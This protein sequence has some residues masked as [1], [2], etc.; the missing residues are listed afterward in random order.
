MLAGPHRSQCAWA[1]PSA[2]TRLASLLAAAQGCRSLA[3]QGSSAFARAAGASEWRAVGRPIMACRVV[4]MLAP[5]GRSCEYAA[6]AS[7]HRLR[8]VDGSVLRRVVAMPAAPASPSPAAERAAHH[9]RRSQQRPGHVR[10][11]AGQDAQPR[12]PRRAR[13]P[14][15]P[16]L[17]PVSAVQP[18]PCLAPDR[19]AAGHDPGPRSA[20][21]FPDACCR[22]SSRCRRCSGATA[23]SPRA[24]ARSTTTAIPG[25]SARAGST[26]R[27]RGKCSSTRAASTRTKRRKLTNF[28]PARGLGSALAY[29]ASPAADEEHTDG[30]VAAET[31]ALLEKHKDRPFFIG[32]GF[33]RPHCPVHRAA[34][35]LRS[36]SAGQDSRAGRIAGVDGARRR[37]GSPTRRTGGS[38]S[39]RSGKA[40]GRTTRRSAFSTRTSAGSSTRSIACGLTDNTIVVFVSDHGYHLGEHGQWM[41]QTLFERSARAPLDR[42]RPGRRREGARDVEGRRVRSTSIPT[43]AALAGVRAAARSA[44]PLAD[45]APEESGRE[46][47]PPGAHA[48]PQRSGGGDVHGLQHSHRE[49][50]IH[51]MGRGQAGRGAVRRGR[52]SAASRTTSLKTRQHQKVVADMQR[53]LQRVSRQRLRP[54]RARASVPQRERRGPAS[55]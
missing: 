19:A 8:T 45:A 35:V 44:R 36:V 34:E 6:H 52:R 43:L 37:R 39:R 33:Y 14:L 13:R 51:G 49:V 5:Q 4:A 29:Y 38:A 24:S 42:R 40:S 17:H 27:R 25:R 28:T 2:A 31:I 3:P 50:A 21:G 12:S 53:L 55:S 22:T 47:G 18:E 7:T 23:T 41:K 26:T 16:R 11:P 48:G 54:A 30:K 32:A 9:G 20:D 15:R 46:V 1:P 10:A